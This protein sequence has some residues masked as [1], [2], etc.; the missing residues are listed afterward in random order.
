LLINPLY[1]VSINRLSKNSLC[2]TDLQIALSAAEDRK[3]IVPVSDASKEDRIRDR[4]VYDATDRSTPQPGLD[5]DEQTISAHP[6]LSNKSFVVQLQQFHKILIKAVVNIV[7]R[8]WDHTASFPSR[9]PLEPAA[10]EMLKVSDA[11]GVFRW[12]V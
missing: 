1:L 12:L 5:P 6:I 9:M 3:Q 7:D 10:E 4:T 8:W 11:E 2:I